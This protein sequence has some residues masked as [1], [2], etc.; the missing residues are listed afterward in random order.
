MSAKLNLYTSK[1]NQPV[2]DSSHRSLRPEPNQIVYVIH[3]GQGCGCQKLKHFWNKDDA[4]RVATRLMEKLD[5][6]AQSINFSCM[7]F[8]D[9]PPLSYV[10]NEPSIKK[11]YK[12]EE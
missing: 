7:S 10:L 2:W 1:A 11:C 6:L 12:H 3:I 4:V 8:S 9:I 5:N